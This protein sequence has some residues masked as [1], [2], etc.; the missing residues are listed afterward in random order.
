MDS[1]RYIDTMASDVVIVSD[2]LVQRGGAERVVE[3]MAQAFPEA[4]I[5]AL[6]Y[7]AATGPEALSD[8]VKESWLARIP[9]A[10][11]RHRAL[12]P[13]F[14]AAVE[15]FDLRSHRV[16]LSSHHTAAKGALRTADQTHICYCYTPMRALW[17]RPFEELSSLPGIARPFAG[18]LF[19]SLRSWDQ[20]SVARVDHF[21]ACSETTRKRIEKHYRRDSEVL[22]PPI[23]VDAFT[24]GGEVGD[25]YLVASRPVPYKRIDVAIDAA[26]SLGRRLL[27]VGGRKGASDGCVTYLGHVS[28][29]RLLQ[30]MRGARALLF[31]QYE[32]FGMTTLEMNACGRPVIAFAKGGAL[33]TVVDEVTGIHVQEQT[34]A[35]FAE[36]IKRFETLTFDS[37]QIRKHALKFSKAAFIE[38]LQEIIARHL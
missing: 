3:A 32:D 15:S 29:D 17:E 9:Q 6:L 18:A 31:P 24:P 11:R 4:P 14:P 2:P 16:I 22:Y 25:Y 1:S 27:I 36:G 38:R 19:R 23:D 37:G 28:D 12:L 5:H 21:I 7:S 26:K 34:P 13:L 30:L 20:A 8:R 35:R 10:R 33:E